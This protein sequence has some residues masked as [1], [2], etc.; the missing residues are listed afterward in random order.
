[1]GL[2]VEGAV[3]ISRETLARLGRH[4]SIDA[5]DDL[6]EAADAATLEAG[7]KGR[8]PLP[9]D[10]VAELRQAWLDDWLRRLTHPWDEDDRGSVLDP[11][12]ELRRW[13]RQAL[14][15]WRT[16]AV[17][18]PE[19]SVALWSAIVHES[20]GGRLPAVFGLLALD[21]LGFAVRRDVVS[22]ALEGYPGDAAVRARVAEVLQP[23]QSRA[24][25]SIVLE[26]AAE[27]AGEGWTLDDVPAL[28]LDTDR[29][30]AA[31][32]LTWITEQL[33]APAEVPSAGMIRFG[34]MDER[35]VSP[36]EGLAAWVL[37][38]GQLRLPNAPP[39]LVISDPGSPR[40]LLVALEQGGMG[41]P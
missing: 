24:R 14:W 6:V 12:A 28:L 32:V 30:D 7:L 4:L 41:N 29:S 38:P 19:R 25:H 39:G 33:D 40:G 9:L 8:G 11:V 15:R 5:L 37:G 31:A 22:R 23:R 1:V 3:R 16:P 36:S 13:P 2:L 34:R 17:A 20:F 10:A 18:E 26:T 27:G 35:R 21:R